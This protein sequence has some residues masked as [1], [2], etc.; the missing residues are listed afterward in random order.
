M[1]AGFEY[2][3]TPNWSFGVEYDHLFMGD[4]NNSFSVLPPFAG[5][6]ANNRISQDVDMVTLRVNYRFGGHEPRSQRDTDLGLV[7][8]LKKNRPAE[9]PAYC[10]ASMMHSRHRGS[11]AADLRR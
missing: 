2:G 4:A 6:F 11:A 1:G 7:R 8:S 9:M 3:F 5:N 10:F